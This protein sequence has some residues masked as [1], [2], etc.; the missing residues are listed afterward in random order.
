M[1]AN[2]EKFR[3]LTSFKN[4]E[5]SDEETTAM[6][7]V[8]DRSVMRMATTEIYDEKLT[9]SIDGSNTIF[10]TKNKPIADR[11]LDR[12]ISTGDVSV[13]LATKDSEN[14]RVSTAATVSSVVSRD[15]RILLSAAPTT[16]TAELGVFC[17]YRY[18]NKAAMDFYGLEQA[19]IYYLA[20]LAAMRIDD[21][22]ANWKGISDSVLSA[23]IRGRSGALGA[24]K[25]AVAGKK[26]LN[27][28]IRTLGL[29]AGRSAGKLAKKRAGMKIGF[30]QEG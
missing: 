18:Y 23:V 29:G 1:Y 10:T 12:K 26:W 15:G 22:M 27:L 2:L 4:D 20:F 9:G 17:D 13:F 16:T 11:D 30:K 21:K 19:A 14:N 25:E 24:G 3:Q 28:C 5:I 7:A 6:I 8:A